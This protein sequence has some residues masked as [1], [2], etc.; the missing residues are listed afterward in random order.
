MNFEKNAQLYKTVRKPDERLTSKIVEL[1]ELPKGSVIADIGAGTGNYSVELFNC[2]YEVFAIEPCHAM[3]SQCEN[4]N[5][6]WIKSYAEQIELS[7]ATVDG[8][9]VINAIHHFHDVKK[10]ITEIY[11]IMKHGTLLIFTF[12]PIILKKVW[13]YDYW[14]A[15][16]DYVDKAYLP[17]LDIILNIESIFKNKVEEI[18]FELPPDFKDG[19][20]TSF[21]KNPFLL[22]NENIRQANST[23]TSME[24]EYAKNG[25][26]RLSI[27]L[28]NGIWANKYSSILNLS[29][30]D[31]GCRILRCKK[32]MDSKG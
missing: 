18:V 14:D 26:Q 27:E 25:L 16:H 21:W 12:D 24:N 8:A 30:Y 17:I 7:N 4:V 23:Y 15:L 9:V 5:I 1:L 20:F 3:M 22:L 29:L 10:A 28:S 31:V 32:P 19:F 11:R 2:G 13:L 6:K